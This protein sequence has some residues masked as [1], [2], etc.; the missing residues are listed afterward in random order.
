MK[1]ELMFNSADREHV[2][3][4]TY[5]LNVNGK[6]CSLYVSRNVRNWTMKTKSSKTR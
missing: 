6:Q 4:L 2:Y 3:L 1:T 5:L